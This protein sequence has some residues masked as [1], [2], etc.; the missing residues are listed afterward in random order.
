MRVWRLCH[1]Y[2]TRKWR[3]D[4]QESLTTTSS[5]TSSTPIPVPTPESNPEGSNAL[6]SAPRCSGRCRL[7][8]TIENPLSEKRMRSREGVSFSIRVIASEW[9]SRHSTR[10]VR[11]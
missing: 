8:V 11:Q 7:A 4:M 2:M 10:R 1:W 6:R 5:P 3:R 9:P